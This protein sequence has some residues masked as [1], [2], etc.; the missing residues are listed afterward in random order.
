M[1][2][3]WRLPCAAALIVAALPG[4]GSAQ[5]LDYPT[6]GVPR[7]PGR[8]AQPVGSRAAHRRRQAGSER[9]V[10]L[11]NPR[12]LRRPLQRFPALSGVHEP[13]REPERPRAL[14]AGRGGSCMVGRKATIE[15]LT[16]AHAGRVLS[17]EIIASRVPTSS[18]GVANP[19]AADTE[20]WSR[21]VQNGTDRR[22]ACAAICFRRPPSGSSNW[23]RS[24][25]RR[26]SNPY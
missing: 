3:K 7:T 14:P 9:Y 25:G 12:E 16:G 22:L 6:P 11:G 5:W 8:Q 20:T 1:T 13:R 2:L 4:A 24:G 10:G 19:N 17:C 23:P 18:T 26:I 21:N 15:A